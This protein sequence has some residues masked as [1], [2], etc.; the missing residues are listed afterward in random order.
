MGPIFHWPLTAQKSPV[1]LPRTGGF[2]CWTSPLNSLLYPKGKSP[3]KSSCKQIINQ[4]TEVSNTLDKQN[5]TCFKSF[6]TKNWNS[7]FLQATSLHYFPWPRPQFKENYS[8]ISF[9]ASSR[10][11]WQFFHVIFTLCTVL[12]LLLC[13]K[14][15]NKINQSSQ[16]VSFFHRTL[17]LGSPFFFCLIFF[18][19]LSLFIW[20]IKIYQLHNVFRDKNV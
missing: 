13:G 18:N 12:L 9:L 1:L 11:P 8:I 20:R 2:S 3:T 10:S 14:E 4:N 17:P 6:L 5:V 16:F 7:S 15:I 19:N